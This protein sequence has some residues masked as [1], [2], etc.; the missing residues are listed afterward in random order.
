MKEIKIIE[1]DLLCLD[2][3]V[4][5]SFTTTIIISSTKKSMAGKLILLATLM[6]L[7]LSLTTVSSVYIHGS[8]IETNRFGNYDLGVLAIGDQLEITIA[9]PRFSSSLIGKI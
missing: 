1:V 2:F 7:G 5:S 6:T 8:S 4:L 3:N 9:F